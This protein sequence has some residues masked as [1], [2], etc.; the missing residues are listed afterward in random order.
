MAISH[1]QVQ[2]YMNEVIDRIK[3]EIC[4]TKIV[5]MG[6]GIYTNLNVIDLDKLATYLA[7][8]ELKIKGQSA[9]L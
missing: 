3:D 1:S 2:K 8:L 9:S 7:K 4:E 6:L 5:D